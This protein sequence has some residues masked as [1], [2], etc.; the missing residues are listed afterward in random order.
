MA[1]AELS[2]LLVDPTRLSIVSLLAA[3]QWAE[4]G[5]VRDSVGL[6]DSALSK[7]VKTLSTSGHIEVRKGYVGNRPRT[8]LNLS[9]TGRHALQAHIAVLHRIAE[10]AR[11]TGEAHRAQPGKPPS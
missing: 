1:E 4:F 3:T 10:Q 11:Q 9:N 6:T 2:P 5:W 8:W 7:Q